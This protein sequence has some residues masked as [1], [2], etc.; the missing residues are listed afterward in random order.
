[1]GTRSCLG[2][3][4]A[5]LEISKLVPRLVRDYD[6]KLEDSLQG[7]EWH[8]KN[9]FFTKPMDFKVRVEKRRLETSSL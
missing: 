7:R 2:R 8:V 4:I 6:F 1:M 9:F 5:M 3:H